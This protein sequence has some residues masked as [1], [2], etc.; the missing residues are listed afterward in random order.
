MS[1]RIVA[2]VLSV[3]LMVPV[4]PAA[5]AAQAVNYTV[6]AFAT[7]NATTVQQT[8][9]N[10]GSTLVWGTNNTVSGGYIVTVPAN[11]QSGYLVV[12]G[13]NT[14]TYA[15]KP[16]N[17]WA[18]VSSGYFVTEPYYYIS[19]SISSTP[20]DF[21]NDDAY[22][23]NGEPFTG[24]VF[25]PAHTS[26]L[27]LV[28]YGKQTNQ[29]AQN[30]NGAR[31]LSNAFIN[32]VPETAGPDYSSILQQILSQLQGLK[33]DASSILG[34]VTSTPEENQA[35]QAIV[36]QIEQTMEEI[37]ELNKQI[38]DN[39]NRPDPDDLLPSA[40]AELLP[41]SDDAAAAGYEV[42]S[43]ILASPLMLSLLVMVFTLAFVRYVLFGKHD[44]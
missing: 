1:K 7:F 5:S 25:V 38:E 20:M 39:T 22:P 19:S 28:V 8:T 6:T 27:Y 3:L 44:G 18:S 43:S 41:P 32:F 16:S 40:P 9:L 23:F 37:E 10:K 31:A 13:Y 36:D 17:G 26:T 29:A 35:A 30:Y 14:I 24:I 33:S 4:L 15:S 11:A 42:V 34:Q 12:A 2:V 21:T